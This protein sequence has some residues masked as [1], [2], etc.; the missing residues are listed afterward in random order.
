MKTDGEFCAIQGV[1]RV[2]NTD[3]FKP[4][5][6]YGLRAILNVSGTGTITDQ[7]GFELKNIKM[8]CGRIFPITGKA[9]RCPNEGECGAKECWIE[10]YEVEK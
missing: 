2:L 4:T 7:I 3:D 1:G 6:V 9:T 10:K 8:R 5:R